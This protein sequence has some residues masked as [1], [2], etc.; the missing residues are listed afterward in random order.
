[1]ERRI[2][3]VYGDDLPDP[4]D[5]AYNVFEMLERDG[6]MVSVKGEIGDMSNE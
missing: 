1:M 4:E 2:I 6:Y 5:L 3:E